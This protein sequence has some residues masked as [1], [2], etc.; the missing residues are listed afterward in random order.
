MATHRQNICLLEL[1]R[2]IYVVISLTLFPF[3]RQ[4][5]SVRIYYFQLN[6]I[7][8]CRQLCLLYFKV[9]YP[10][11]RS[12]YSLL[13]AVAALDIYSSSDPLITAFKSDGQRVVGTIGPLAKVQRVGSPIGKI[14]GS[15]KIIMPPPTARDIPGIVRPPGTGA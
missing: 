13:R 15:L 9:R 1:T 2:H 6:Y 3:Y 8:R 11:M 4:K 12:F 7:H 10:H 14:S 5:M